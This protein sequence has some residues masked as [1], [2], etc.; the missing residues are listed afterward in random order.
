MSTKDLDILDKMP[1]WVL[2]APERA[3]MSRYIKANLASGW[4]PDQIASTI[5]HPGTGYPATAAQIRFSFPEAFFDNVAHME[6]TAELYE[7]ALFGEKGDKTKAIMKWVETRLPEKWSDPA[8]RIEI[9]GK[10]GNPIEVQ[11]KVQAAM[12]KANKIIDAMAFNKR[13]AL[14]QA[15][16]EAIDAEVE[17]I[18]EPALIERDPLDD[19]ADD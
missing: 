13:K 7:T 8:K 10:D 15:K 2:E 12:A 3:K 19:T 6:I 4:T 16:E 1:D 18:L 11:H 17:E 5:L 14:E 9:T